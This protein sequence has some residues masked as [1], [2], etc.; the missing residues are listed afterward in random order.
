MFQVT[1]GLYYSAAI[2]RVNA[3][4]DRKRGFVT[5]AQSVFGTLFV[6]VGGGI[7][8]IGGGEVMNR[9]GGRTMYR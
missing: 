4:T 8:S 1:F 7:G 2:S 5:T 6:C 9:Y 3:V